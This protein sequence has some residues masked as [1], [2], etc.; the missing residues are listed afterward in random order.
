MA[1]FKLRHNVEFG[2]SSLVHYD[3][4]CTFD[5]TYNEGGYGGPNFIPSAATAARVEITPPG[6]TSA[7]TVDV[8]PSLPNDS[9]DGLEITLTDLGLTEIAV[10]EWKV[11]YVVTFVTGDI[12][13]VECYFL[14][15]EPVECCLSKKAASTDPLCD[16]D[17][18]LKLANLERM[19]ES[20]VA[21]HCK[22]NYSKAEEIALYVNKQCNCCC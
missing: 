2:S 1:N 16:L 11:K 4:T 17:G 15:T 3:T 12:E 19:L 5:S 20:A 14:N 18:F 13:E 21:N 6:A 7:I 10:G 22:G 9:G 8:F